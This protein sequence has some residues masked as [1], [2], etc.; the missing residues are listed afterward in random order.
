[1][2][3][4]ERLEENYN[5]NT[6][7]TLFLLS[8]LCL[9]CDCAAPMMTAV[10]QDSGPCHSSFEAARAEASAVDI[11]APV[12][13]LLKHHRAGLKCQPHAL[14]PWTHALN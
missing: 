4:R 13:G 3:P 6:Y 1:M 8:N 2:G 7:T 12:N 10:L 11:Q 9:G 5:S 14:I